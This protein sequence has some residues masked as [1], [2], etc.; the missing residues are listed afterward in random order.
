MQHVPIL[1]HG[2]AQ[3]PPRRFKNGCGTAGCGPGGHEGL[4][5]PGQ[6]AAPHGVVPG[7]AQQGDERLRAG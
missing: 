7:P 1:E 6:Q 5:E 3:L 2:A 4:A